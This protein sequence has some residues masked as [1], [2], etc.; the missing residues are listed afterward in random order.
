MYVERDRE[1]VNAKERQEIHR[2]ESTCGEGERDREI[3]N[4][5]EREERTESMCGEGERDRR[6]LPFFTC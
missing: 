1:I 4:A 5:K 6:E 2:T 3:V